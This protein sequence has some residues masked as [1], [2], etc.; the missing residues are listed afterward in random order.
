MVLA[1]VLNPNRQTNKER[2]SLKLNK[3]PR[4]LP[5]ISVLQ[6]QRMT[7]TCQAPI[8]RLLKV[9]KI[10]ILLLRMNILRTVIIKAGLQW[11]S[12]TIHTF[13]LLVKKCK[14]LISQPQELVSKLAVIKRVII[15]ITTQTCLV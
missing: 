11:A 4:L 5:K 9:I 6:C 12:T 10:R 14:L 3:I 1:I 8:S 13:H 7:V 15:I 2:S